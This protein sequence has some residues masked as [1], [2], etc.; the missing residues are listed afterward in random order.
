MWMAELPLVVGKHQRNR[1]ETKQQ[2]KQRV[3]DFIERA[4]KLPQ[5]LMRADVVPGMRVSRCM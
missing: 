3:P 5:E 2:L 1:I 4:S